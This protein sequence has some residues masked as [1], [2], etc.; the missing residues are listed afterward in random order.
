M[1]R[2][3]PHGQGDGRRHPRAV[4]ERPSGCP[5]ENGYPCACSC[6][7]GKGNMEREVAAAPQGRVGAI[8]TRRDVAGY[9]IYNTDGKSLMFTYPMEVKS[10]ITRPSHA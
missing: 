2:S 4:P 1:S 10:V 3:I 6:P 7:A 9:T 5:A 8:M